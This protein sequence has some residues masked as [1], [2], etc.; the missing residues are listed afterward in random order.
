MLE[1][2]ISPYSFLAISFILTFK[3]LFNNFLGVDIAYSCDFEAI[4][5][6]FFFF[7]MFPERCPFNRVH[8]LWTLF[9][10]A[11]KKAELF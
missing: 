6:F 11:V 4:L 1:G 9:S 10:I 5:F 2:N 7:V 3:N 8:S